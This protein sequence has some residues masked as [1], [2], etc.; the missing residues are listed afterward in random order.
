MVYTKGNS[1]P[2]LAERLRPKQISEIIG[3]KELLG[4]DGI[5][6]EQIKTGNIPSMIFWGQAG[7]GKTTLALAIAKTLNRSFYILN[8][9]SDGVKSI[10]DI[11]KKIDDQSDTLFQDTPIVFIDEIHRFTKS[12]QDSL[13]SIV[14]KGK[15]TLI[16][17]TTENPS[18][19]IINPLLSRCNIYV[20][21]PLTDNDLIGRERQNNFNWGNNRK[22]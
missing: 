10:R 17:A 21:Q 1:L 8:A 19:E 3:H 12:Q 5:I 2:P 14:E 15:I 4:H 16:G 13:L 9:T 20:L 18:F 11:I 6:T 7:I 22:S